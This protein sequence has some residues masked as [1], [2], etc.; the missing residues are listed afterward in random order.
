[1]G[2][3]G[4]NCVLGS[5]LRRLAPRAKS[6]IAAGVTPAAA[7]TATA[8]LSAGFKPGSLGA[9]RRNFPLRPRPSSI[10]TD[11]VVVG[12]N[13]TTD[14]ETA[15]APKAGEDQGLASCTSRRS[16][17]SLRASGRAGAVGGR[18]EQARRSC[19][20]VNARVTKRT[21]WRVT[22]LTSIAEVRL[23]HARGC[24]PAVVGARLL[25]CRGSG[26]VSDELAIVR[27]GRCGS[28]S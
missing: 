24:G 20:K 16:L 12:F 9:H 21:P 10:A 18:G 27:A 28:R 4:G 3:Y 22:P 26:S 14:T 17:E 8:P 13:T 1:V 2:H 15:P 7:I 11:G 19:G 6:I 5:S 23:R 25:R